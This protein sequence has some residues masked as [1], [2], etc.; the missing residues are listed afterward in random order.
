MPVSPPANG[1][2]YTCHERSYIIR[3]CGVTV[4]VRDWFERDAAN[5]EIGGRRGSSRQ[6]R[7]PITSISRD[8]GRSGRSK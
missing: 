3:L 1:F 4:C 8:V 5:P 6:G 2:A 7:R